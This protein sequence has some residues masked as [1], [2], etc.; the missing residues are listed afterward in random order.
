ML[1]R[2]E[3]I[4]ASGIF[5]N[6]CWDTTLPDLARINV[7]FGRN[8][9]GK[10]SLASALD[11]LRHAADSEGFK[12]VSVTLDDI[13][14]TRTTGFN[15]DAV[16]D[17][18]HVFSDH[19]VTRNHRFSPAAVEMD[20]VLTIGERPVD[21]E[22][23][24]EELRQLVTAKCAERDTAAAAEREAKQEVEHAYRQVSQKVVD[25]ASRAGG[26]WHSKSNFSV[27]VVKTAFGRSHDAWAELNDGELREKIALLNSDKSEAL[28]QVDFAVTVR[29]DLHEHLRKSL[30]ATPSTIVLDTLAARPDATSWVDAGR[31]LHGDADICIFCGSDLTEDR[32]D[33]IDQHFSDEVEKLQ[34]DLKSISEELDEICRDVD[35]ALA[36]I[37][38]KGLFFEDLRSQIDPA[39]DS[40]RSELLALKEWAATTKS[41]VGTKAENVLRT[42][43]P[44]VEPAPIVHGAELLRLRS[45]HNARVDGHEIVVKN[46]AEAVERHYLKQA[47]SLV[48]EKGDLAAK[49][50]AEVETLNIE[51][52]GYGAEITALENVEGDPMPSA[53]VLT[54]E[55]ARLLGRSELTF[56]AVDGRYRVSRFGQ[57]ASGLSAGERTAITLVH[58][59]ESVA[60][61]D[62]ANGKPIVVIDDPV[63]SLDSDIFMGVSTYIW[64]EA[65]VK[66]HIDQLILLTH[67]FELFRQWDIQIDG[68]HQVRGKD[69]STGLTFRKLYSAQFYEIRSRH[70]TSGEH[71]KRQPVLMP[72]PPSEKSRRKV[73][74]S[75]HHA[76]ICVADALRNLAEQDSLENRLDA[77]LLFPNVVRRM[78]ET[79]LAFK[80]PEW[81]GDF[82]N[83]MRNS[84]ELLVEAG[85]R[86]DANA[87]RLRLTRYAHAHSH[88]EDPSTDKT[89]SPDEAATAIGAVFE[90][91][92]LLDGPH[93][94]GLCSTVGIEPS[95]LLPP[96]LPEVQDEPTPSAAN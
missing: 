45:E 87:L 63:S 56:D 29:S 31:H 11:G 37:P 75:Y 79:F 93:F 41:C 49:K 92:H 19:Y 4:K 81:V 65:V 18:I 50:N 36:A 69:K 59:L 55:V 26:R 3:R 54:E 38:A 46:A 23:R 33:L 90:F 80:R 12:R 30:L 44:T 5:E 43:D 88:A 1:R 96:P 67:N 91:M 10:T 24:L 94:V 66:D 70:V 84:A 60:R 85:Y 57:P 28:P 73:R 83:A 71:T 15:M 86:G 47:E 77:Q 95:E 25:A 40:L 9:T 68:L 6:F 74:S 82:N 20:A 39:V 64:A 89:V 32:R 34:A 72:W 42:V 21:A 78:L 58:F 22:K 16:F 14:G 53:K 51:L 8:G 48:K 35:L 62:T 27:G 13:S 7:I 17:R 76:F 2:L 61:F 52:D